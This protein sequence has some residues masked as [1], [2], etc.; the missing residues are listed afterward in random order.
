M[1]KKLAKRKIVMWAAMSL[2]MAQSAWS[3]TIEGR[4]SRGGSADLSDSVVSVED[5]ESPLQPPQK[6]A[7]EMNQKGLRFVPHV[8]A[9]QAG[10]TVDFP[11]SDPVSHN[12]FSISDAKRFN[13]GLYGRGMKRSIRFDRPGVVELLCNVHMEMSGYIVVLKN[14]YFVQPGTSGAFRIAG[15]PAGRHRVRC[16]HEELPAQE[17]EINVP[18]EG[19]ASVNFDMNSGPH[20]NKNSS[21]KKEVS[22]R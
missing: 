5:I 15:V 22:G 13:L 1:R 10:N 18:S 14:R 19:V 4:V 21:H 9:I 2:L 3:G 8:L 12:V 17:E 20:E 7:P 16:W 6:A 11:N